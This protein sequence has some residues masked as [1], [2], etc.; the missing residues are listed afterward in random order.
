LFTVH[1]RSAE[2]GMVLVA[3]KELHGLGFVH[4]DLKPENIP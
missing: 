4:R 1:T 3:L 2:H